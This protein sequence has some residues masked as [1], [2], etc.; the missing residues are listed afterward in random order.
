MFLNENKTICN[1]IE[2]K[3]TNTELQ[4]YCNINKANKIFLSKLFIRSNWL[5]IVHKI[6]FSYND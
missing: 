2:T 4:F 5:L 1:L 6:F 3:I